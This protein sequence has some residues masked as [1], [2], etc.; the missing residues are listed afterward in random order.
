[1]DI[2][3]KAAH[4][5]NY[6]LGRTGDTIQY[7]VIHYT[8]SSSQNGDTAVG[9]A[10]YF[11]S[12]NREASAHYFVDEKEIYQ[13]V[14]DGDTAW[15]VGGK[16]YTQKH[17]ICRN[18]NSI[19]IELCSGLKNGTRY[20]K[21]GAIP[22]ATELVVH[23]MLKYNIPIENVLRHFDVVSKICPEPFVRDETA[24]VNFLKGVQKYMDELNNRP[25]DWAKEAWEYGVKFG[26]IA[27]DNPRN[28]VTKEQVMTMIYKTVKA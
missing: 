4:G 23:L 18:K 11:S 13:T 10:T 1:M 5:T 14:K 22:I 25:S 8:G 28:P 15:S 9:N 6:N 17:P 2:K 16:A 27:D 19:S 24:W 26:I 7:I 21:Q 20:I 12:P 3:I